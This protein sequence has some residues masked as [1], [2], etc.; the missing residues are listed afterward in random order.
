VVDRI[1]QAWGGLDIL[2][3]NVGGSGSPPGGFDVLSDQFWQSIL[4]V[5]LLAA[6]RL[7]RAFVPGMMERKS[8]VVLH[9]GSIAYRQPS[10]PSLAYA[11]AK[12]A[13]RSYSKGLS[14]AAAPGGVRVNMISPGFIETEGAL[15]FIKDVQKGSGGT[16]DEARQTIIAMIGGI[17]I[18]R[19]GSPAEVAE[20]AAF[21]ASDQG[22]F[23]IGTDCILDG[24]TIPTV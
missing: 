17:P 10:P 7:D 11:T 9:I 4:E 24:G 21:L 22:A 6:V 18:G 3:N 20:L 2:I 1:Q 23:M 13:L 8:G 14:K 15:G 12:G 19:T 5:N 16:E